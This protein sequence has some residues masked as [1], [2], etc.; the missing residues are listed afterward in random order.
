MGRGALLIVFMLGACSGGGD[1]CRGKV[2]VCDGHIRDA[3]GRALILRGVNLAGAHKW[4][5]YFGFQ[6]QADYARVRTDWGL[7]AARFL[8]VWAAVEPE[9]GQY[10]DDYLD[11]VA[12]RLQWAHDAG[13]SVILDMHQDLYGEGFT[14]GDG[15]PRWTCDSAHY[16]AFVPRDPWFLGYQDDNV[17]ACVDGFW[18]SEELQAAYAAAWRHVAERL[19]GEPAVI[20]FDVMNEPHWGTYAITS[21]EADRLQPMY[22]RVVPEVR[23]AAPDWIAFLEPSSARNGGFATGLGVTPLPA[24][25][26][27]APHSY[28]FQAE[29]GNGF[30]PERRQALI[31]NAVLL[32]GEAQL[33]GAALWVGEYGGQPDDPGI[34]E[35]MDAQYDAFG[36]VAASSMYWSYDRGGYGLLDADGNEQTAL[37]DVI[38]RPYAERIAGQPIGWSFDETTS[39]F[40]LRWHADAGIAAPTEIVI[41]SR[42]Y[43]AGFAVSCGD[44]SYQEIDQGVQISTPPSG[45]PA[46]VTISP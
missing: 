20:G 32:A 30:T 23:A 19:A 4:A 5:P 40:E 46:V 17:L 21:F 6:E 18:T 2:Q 13:L 29:S 10:D 39:T 9:Q 41:P 16:D 22:E 34:A 15:A 37:V 25:V 26:A 7:N 28:D 33:L 38:A 8:L 14:G 35:Y 27:Y 12:L 31:D 1:P 3:D 42:A 36:A 24:N 45:D 43:P 11:Q 44:C